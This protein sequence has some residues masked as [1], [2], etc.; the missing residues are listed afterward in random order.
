MKEDIEDQ[1]IP[2][3]V[4]EIRGMVL[5]STEAFIPRK[6][7]RSL[8]V[9]GQDTHW[10]LLTI[11]GMFTGGIRKERK[12]GANVEEVLRKYLAEPL[13]NYISTNDTGGPI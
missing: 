6:I 1:E 5:Q 12:K 10:T 8:K 3:K 13:L 7:V 2:E 9:T 11:T 4:Y